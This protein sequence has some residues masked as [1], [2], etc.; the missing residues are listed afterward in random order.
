MTIEAKSQEINQ[1]AIISGKIIV[2]EDSIY[3]L[4]PYSIIVKKD[5]PIT[6][7]EFKQQRID[8]LDFSFTLRMDLDELT[9]GFITINFSPDLDTSAMR[10]TGY[11]TPFALPDEFLLDAEDGS[12]REF[13]SR[14]LFGG[15]HFIAEPDDSLHMLINYD[16]ADQYRR[17]TVHFSGPGGA[18]NNY[19]RSK[20]PSMWDSKSFKLP[21]EEGLVQED[22]LMESKL[23]DLTLAKDSISEA[24]FNLLKTDIEFDNLSMK[25]ALIRASLYGPETKPEYK[26]A[27]ARELYNYMDTLTLKDEY[28]ISSEFRGFLSLYLEYINRIITGED[29][30]YSYDEKNYYLARSI[31]KKDILKNFLY[32]RLSYQMEQ[33]N[34]YSTKAYQ[35]EEF[36]SQFPNTPESNRLTR[37]HNKRFPVSNGQPA[38]DLELID[39]LG[40]SSQLSDLK[41]KVVLITNYLSG[42]NNTVE[43]QNQMLNLSEKFFGTELVV[44]T[45]VNPHRRSGSTFSPLVDYYVNREFSIENFSSYLFL[46]QSAYTFIVGKNGLIKDCVSNLNIADETISELSLERFTLR[47]RVNDYLQDHSRQF[48]V[49]LSIL[50]S[51]SIVFVLSIQLKQRRQ[52]LIRKQLNSELKAIRSQLNPH[53]LFNSLNSIQN[54]INKSDKKTANLHLSKFSMLMRKVIEMSEKGST[55]LQE[56]L[57]FNRT[58]IEL[59]QLRYGFKCNFDIDERIDLY[60]T[61]I[62]SMIIQ[63]FIENAIVHCM[64]E[65]GAKGELGIFLKEISPEEIMVEITDNGQGFELGAEKGFGLKSSRERIDLLNSQSKEKIKLQIESGI[66]SKAHGGSKVR[67]IIPKKY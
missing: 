6:F 2:N 32:D 7:T 16:K 58:F 62:P 25:H 12:I 31:Y 63:P 38:P 30:A 8:T 60:N 51:L 41:G 14:I 1:T 39:S 36:I 22:L 35:L 53:F 65:L 57:D 24:Y 64:S 10:N 43:I 54:F 61:E 47:T 46:R 37:I 19:M 29:I 48:I 56:E 50:L 44:V 11:W 27:R 5:W 55:S 40:R 42:S 28:L 59:E 66:H 52:S 33:T 26:R 34:F 21:V 18:N 13:A 15:V 4:M 23:K 3:P 67:L 20:Y 49:V 17:P 45:L 9:S